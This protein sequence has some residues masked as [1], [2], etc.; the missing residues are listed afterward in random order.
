MAVGD[1]KAAEALLRDAQRGAVELAES[2]GGVQPLCAAA[3]KALL[4]AALLARAKPTEVGGGGDPKAAKEAGKVLARAMRG[5]GFGTTLAAAC[6]TLGVEAELAKGGGGE[7]DG[8]GAIAV[9]AGR[10][11]RGWLGDARSGARGRR[12]AV[13]VVAA[14][15]GGRAEGCA[16]GALGG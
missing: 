2:S 15:E 9:G 3:S 14:R 11:G 4:G 13:R 5:A 12:T 8:G 10:L 6:G 16:R 1:F 7:G